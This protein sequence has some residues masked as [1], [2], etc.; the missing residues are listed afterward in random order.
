MNKKEVSS[1]SLVYLY[2]VEKL[3]GGDCL[4][5]Y[6]LALIA[7]KDIRWLKEIKKIKVDLSTA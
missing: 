2:E 7:S 3:L 4:S 5:S 6:D 1:S